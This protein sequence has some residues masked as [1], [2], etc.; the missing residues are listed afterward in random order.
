M[1]ALRGAQGG[2][3][4]RR[5]RSARHSQIS[6]IAPTAATTS[7]ATQPSGG[8]TLSRRRTV[9]RKSAPITPTR[10]LAMIPMRLW[11]MRSA[12]QPAIPPMMITPMKPR[13]SIRLTL[14]DQTGDHDHH[15]GPDQRHHQ[16]LEEGVAGLQ[17]DPQL[18]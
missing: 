4:M 5:P 12:I 13:P 1:T 17:I 6:R 10:M 9:L 16:P 3:V 8:T 7:C 11:V 14:D 18:L 15:H 2:G